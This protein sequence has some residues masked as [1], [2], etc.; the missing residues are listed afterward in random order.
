MPTQPRHSKE[1]FARR[2]DAI[3]DR[4]RPAIESAAP[5][6]FVAIDIESEAYEIDADEILAAERLTERHPQAQIWIQRIGSRFAR[7]IGGR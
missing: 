2:G 3:Y 5:G 4:L 7:R 6:K 1:E